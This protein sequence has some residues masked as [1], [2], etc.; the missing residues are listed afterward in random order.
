MLVRCK[1]DE[2]GK[3]CKEKEELVEMNNEMGKK[4]EDMLGVHLS[5]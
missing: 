5:A 2:V 4:E 1:M 3:S